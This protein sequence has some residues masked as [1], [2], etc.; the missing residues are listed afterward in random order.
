[1]KRFLTAHLS[2][3]ALLLT[4]GMG[5]QAA[6]IP[7]DQIQWNYNFAPTDPAVYAHNNASAG[8]TFTNE[9]TKSATGSSDVVVTNL[10]VFSAALASSPDKLVGNEGAYTVSLTLSATD[11]NGLHTG[12][13]TFTGKLTGTFSSQSANVANAFDSTAAKT[14][15]LGVYSFTVKLISY[16]PPGPPDQSNAGSISAH[17]TVSNPQVTQV[18]EPA[19]LMLSGLGLTFLGGAAWRKRRRVRVAA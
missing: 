18:P 16:T 1:M 10:R 19:S 5:A 15:A 4:A 2:A 13:L 14:L 7:P 9:P 3:L 8:V 11:T 17:V 6:P 12:T